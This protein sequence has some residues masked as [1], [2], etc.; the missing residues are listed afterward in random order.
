M[1]F[2]TTENEGVETVIEELCRLTQSLSIDDVPEPMEITPAD[3]AVAGPSG[4]N[5]APRP[6]DRVPRPLSPAPEGEENGEAVPGPMIVNPAPRP[7]PFPYRYLIDQ[8]VTSRYYVLPEVVLE[9]GQDA[10]VFAAMR[11]VD[12]RQVVLKCVPVDLT[13]EF[14]SSLLWSTSYR[15]YVS[16]CRE[17]VF[18]EIAVM[19]DM[20]VTPPCPHVIHMLDW[21]EFPDG[22]MLVLER[23]SEPWVRMD[24][25]VQENGGELSETVARRMVRQLLETF[26]FFTRHRVMHGGISSEKV[27]INRDTLR[28]KVIGFGRSSPSIVYD[29]EG[30][31][32]SQPFYENARYRHECNTHHLY[33]MCCFIHVM[34]NL[35]IREDHLTVLRTRGIS[36]ECID[37]YIVC[38]GWYNKD[39][40]DLQNHPWITRD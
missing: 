19:L 37:F 11:R 27:M 2:S 8:R 21:F 3:E 4:I 25:F 29:M 36:R 40:R 38:I 16:R 15:C 22:Y 26:D 14:A 13:N 5:P 1:M 30:T 35:M 7:I 9:H 33:T 20:Q 6:V 39:L 17:P 32:A 31:Q 28:L 34:F 10:M 23:L 24:R 18:K 12:G